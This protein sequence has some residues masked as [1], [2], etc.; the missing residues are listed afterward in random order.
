MNIRSKGYS[1]LQM[2]PLHRPLYHE[3]YP[4]CGITLK[5]GA[6]KNLQKSKHAKGCIMD[7]YA[8]STCSLAQPLESVGH[9]NL[10]SFSLLTLLLLTKLLRS[11]RSIH[12]K[13]NVVPR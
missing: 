12:C 1:K 11:T 6:E 3:Q 2:A 4:Y 5:L 9:V 8:E 10:S 13:K 7:A